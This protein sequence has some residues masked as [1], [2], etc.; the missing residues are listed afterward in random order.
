MPLQ[1]GKCFLKNKIKNWQMDMNG[2]KLIKNWQMDMNGWKLGYFETKKK[3]SPNMN[4][5]LNTS[6]GID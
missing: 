4:N 1:V 2:W 5:P 6:I 3:F